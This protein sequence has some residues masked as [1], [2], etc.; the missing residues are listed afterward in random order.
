[1][2]LQISHSLMI[3]IQQIFSFIE[4]KSIQG[5]SIDAI[6]SRVVI[7]FLIFAHTDSSRKRN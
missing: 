4:E 1:M 6:F 5:F 2:L 7:T 3:A